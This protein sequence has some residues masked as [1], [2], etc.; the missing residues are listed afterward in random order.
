[1]V[2]LVRHVHRVITRIVAVMDA[3]IIHPYKVRRVQCAIQSILRIIVVEEAGGGVMI[4]LPTQ[5]KRGI[6][7]RVHR[8]VIFGRG[9]L[10]SL[11]SSHSGFPTRSH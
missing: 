10:W 2:A 11:S 9:L 4:I 3:N 6:L 1:M 5:S 7:V 8:G